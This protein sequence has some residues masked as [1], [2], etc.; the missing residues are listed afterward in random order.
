M[1]LVFAG[2]PMCSWC[3]GFAKELDAALEQLPPIPFQVRVAGLWAD[4]RQ[5]LDHEAKQFRLSHWSRV[6]AA[7]GVPFNRAA[8]MARER[9][10]YNS[11]PI[12]RAF[13][14]GLHL[15]P[16]VQALRLFR[17]LQRAFYVDGLD[18]TDE[19]VLARVLAKELEEQG[20]PTAAGQAQD[21]M[22][23]EAVHLQV[24]R[25]FAQ[26]RSWRLASFPKLLLTGGTSAK[27][28]L[29]GFANT[30]EIVDAVSSA[31]PRRP[32]DKGS[33]P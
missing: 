2:D 18:T 16:S 25:D 22:N 33:H 26:V 14:A 24:R 3:Y 7:A 19:L 5:L 11:E 23:L 6:E 4:G 17:A 29:Q 10:Y 1:T 32:A 13:V 30:P 31:L 9:F 12:S 15:A 8:L 20:H 27:V 28:L 21:A